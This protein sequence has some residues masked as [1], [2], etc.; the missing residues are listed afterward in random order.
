MTILMT[1]DDGISSP[2]LDLLA[3]SLRRAGHRV[4]VLAPDRNRSGVS[5][6]I[7]FL[8]GPIR[9]RK[10]AEDTWSCEGQPVDCVIIA[11][12]GGLPGLEGPPDMLV[13]G[14]NR[15]ANLGTDIIYSGTAAAARQASLWNLPSLALSLVEGETYYW[16]MAVSYSVKNLEY[17]KGAWKPDIFVN[18]NIPNRAEEPD[19]EEISFPS[20]RFY[21]DKLSPYKTPDG[22]YY[23][24]FTSGETETTPEKGSDWDAVSRGMASVSSIFIH[25][26]ISDGAGGLSSGRKERMA[27]GVRD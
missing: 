23:C 11:L 12:L 21:H 15:G 22:R 9:L 6:S 3:A 8:S 25:P 20:L 24:F 2:G 19:G 13:S 17:F 1:N 10:Y 18:V 5:H 4:F 26:V 7:S 16:D 27:M 14:I